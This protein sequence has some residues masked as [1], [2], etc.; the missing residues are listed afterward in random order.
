V[1]STVAGTSEVLAAAAEALSATHGRVRLHE[2]DVLAGSPR[3]HVVRARA[4]GGHQLPSTVVVKAHVEATTWAAEIREPAALG[5]LTAAGSDLAPRLLAVADEPSLVVLEDLGAGLA[6]LADALLGTDAER[7]ETMVLAW[8]DAMAR[9]HTTTSQWGCDMAVALAATAD[10]LGR[11]TPPVDDMPG[12]L[13]RAAQAIADLLPMLGVEPTAD[14]LDLVRHLNDL[15]GGSQACRALTP[16]D[17]CPD[18]NLLTA[19]GLVLLDF[20]GAQV[21]HV[22]WDAAYLTVPWPSC[23]CSWALPDELAAHALARWR[24]GVATIDPHVASSDF[25]ADLA[26]AEAGWAMISTAWFLE[27]AVRDAAAQVPQVLDAPDPDR[28]AVLLRRLSL[29]MQ[30]TD[31]R[32]GPLR[33]LAKEVH[34]AALAS[35]GAS[36]LALAPAFRGSA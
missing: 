9:L 22:A 5:L 14:A 33:D 6:D 34:D 30:T 11:D 13:G 20:E 19:D 29:A 26:V 8:A 21:R 2:V 25:D 12:A 27:R 17:P 23:W 35:W 18:N 10:R 15:L 7:A 32:L 28:R 1:T 16:S 31:S 36:P 3:S 24:S 4:E